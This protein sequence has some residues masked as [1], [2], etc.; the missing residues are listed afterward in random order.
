MHGVAYLGASSRCPPLQGSA[1]SP[2]SRLRLWGG[3]FVLLTT[4]VVSVIDGADRLSWGLVL[5]GG[6][7]LA[8]EAAA[9]APEGRRRTWRLACSLRARSWC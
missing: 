4:L 1:V 5:L 6:Y 9:R 2:P 3:A 8:E 7:L